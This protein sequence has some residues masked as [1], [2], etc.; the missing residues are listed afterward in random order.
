MFQELRGPRG[1]RGDAGADAYEVWK[2]QGNTGSVEVP[3]FIKGAQRHQLNLVLT[4][5]T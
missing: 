1:Y 2:L 4:M 5:A 3:G